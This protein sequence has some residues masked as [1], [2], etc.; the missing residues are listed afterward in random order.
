MILLTLYPTQHLL[1]THTESLLR[2][3]A[4]KLAASLKKTLGVIRTAFYGH[5]HRNISVRSKRYA[6]P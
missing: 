2:S 6:R 1:H 4:S 5:T 3:T